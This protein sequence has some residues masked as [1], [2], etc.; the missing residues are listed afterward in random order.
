MQALSARAGNQSTP[1]VAWLS[2]QACL[3][4]AGLLF[5]LPC[6]VS[7]GWAHRCF[8][9]P[10]GGE[11]DILFVAWDVAYAPEAHGMVL[12]RAVHFTVWK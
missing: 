10:S 8:M 9:V 3:R 7:S 11:G 4:P 5:P 6:P 2:P 12:L 1:K